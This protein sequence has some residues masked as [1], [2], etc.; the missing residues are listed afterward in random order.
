MKILIL[1]KKNRIT[2]ED[3]TTRDSSTMYKFYKTHVLKMTSLKPCKLVK[4]ETC[5]GYKY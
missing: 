2:I 1:L 3:K 4:R 5:R